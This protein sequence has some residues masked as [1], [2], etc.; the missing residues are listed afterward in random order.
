MEVSG[1]STN[2]DAGS[3]PTLYDSQWGITLAASEPI[4]PDANGYYYH[5]TFE[6]GTDNWKGRGDAAVSVGGKA[7]SGSK[8]LIVSDRTKAWNGAQKTLDAYT[9]KAGESYSFSVAVSG[10]GNMMLSLQYKD[11]SD[12]TKYAH[13]ADGRSS[14]GYVQLANQNYKLPEGS[15][16]ILYVETEEGTEDFTIDEAI[17][18]KSGTKID[19][20]KPIVTTTTATAPVVTTVT[21]A[22]AQDLR[23]LLNSKVKK[24]GDANCDGD[25]DMSDVVFIMQVLANPDKY[26][27]S[28]G[29]A[30]NADV[31]EAGGGIT[32]NDS[33]AIQNFLLG[34]IDKLPES[35]SNNIKT[36]TA[37]ITTTTTTTTT[38]QPVAQVDFSA[39]A[40]KFGSVNLEKSYKKEN[41]HNPL[42]SRYF[43]ADPGV[44]EY[45]GR[46]Y[47]YMTD[48]HLIYNGNNIKENDYN[49]INCL[50]CISSDDLVNWTDHGL[51]NAAGKN[52]LCK[53]GGNSWAPTACHK[54]INGK[55]KFFIYFAN[56]GNGIA[57]LEADSPTGPWR[58]PI[59][60]ALISRSTPNCNNVTWLFDPAVFV[61]DDGKA[62]LYFGGGV[63]NNQNAHPKTARAVQLGDNM[64]S[65]VG[66]PVT[67]DPPYLFEDSGIHK[68]NGKYYYS[69]CS[70]FNTVG[71]NL[72]IT[73]GAINYMV[74]DSPLG[75]F[76]YKGEVFKGIST[77]FGTG[78][79]NHHT[80]LKF[81]DQLYLFY[82]AQYLQ[83]SMGIKGGYRSTHI[84][85]ITVNADGT[86]QP[87]KGTKAGVSQIKSF[88]PF[89]TSRAATFS[90]QGGINISGSGDSIVQA[91]KG[92]WYR[93]SGV[94]CK[95]G[96]NSL[97]IKA[98]AKNGCIIKVCKGSASGTAVA[99]AEIP[100]GGSMQEITV[101]VK[102]LS[103]KNDLY[104][105]FN[106]SASV[107]SWKLS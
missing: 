106:A 67:I 88:D 95:N 23:N 44:M 28:E 93:V 24:W 85:K 94:D 53:W 82:H 56:S 62:Y 55:E 69:Y 102:D 47:I 61:D 54:T 17:V 38:T 80:I 26:K 81:K 75:P 6:S 35:Y 89:T 10:S 18:A 103:G 36:V 34:K 86:M 90:H 49:T 73:N 66:T 4:E 16:Y 65:I 79:N 12:K 42:I 27:F 9:F 51:I 74:S 63:P 83:D 11:A 76:T 30:Y 2:D 3:K 91:N 92:S 84:D 31:S 13:I 99:Y 100:A 25:V 72:G 7:Y 87:V 70:N 48:D 19:V 77:F 20:I 45:N 71:N 32:A 39:M 21:S 59:G 101:P 78:G 29:G 8:A 15:E 98:S 57:V 96:A 1:R 107:D 5:D 104:F 64:T 14:G 58:D 60:K 105:L 68:Y 52:G 97:T 22:P 50:R 46:V 37:P 33:L 40:Q 43:G 41:E